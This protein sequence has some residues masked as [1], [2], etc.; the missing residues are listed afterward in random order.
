MEQQIQTD[1][2]IQ[3]A[4]ETSPTKPL[5]P[6]GDLNLDSIGQSH[7]A[8]PGAIRERSVDGSIAYRV[9]AMIAMILLAIGALVGWY[10]FR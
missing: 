2:P 3:R 4:A 7:P 9:G 10:Y 8:E 5:T 1:V 6:S